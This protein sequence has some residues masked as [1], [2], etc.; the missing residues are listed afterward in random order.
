MTHPHRHKYKTF[1]L[2]KEISFYP[3]S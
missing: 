1:T 3:A 2:R